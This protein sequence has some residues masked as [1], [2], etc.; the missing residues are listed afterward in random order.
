MGGLQPKARLA[1]QG[2]SLSA[3]VRLSCLRGTVPHDHT[4][5]M[6]G[7]WCMCAVISTVPRKQITPH[8]HQAGMRPIQFY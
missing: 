1:W 2:L 3:R 8:M 6:C 4:A 7:A 5:G